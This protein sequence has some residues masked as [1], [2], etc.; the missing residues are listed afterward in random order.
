[1]ND[2]AYEIAKYIANAGYGT[3]GTDVFAGQI[4][5]DQNGIYVIRAGGSLNN[6]NSIANT[7]VDVYI[8]NTQAST[9]ITTLEGIKAYIHRMYDTNID[10]THIYSILVI[11]DVTDVQRDQEYAKVFKITVQVIHRDTGIIS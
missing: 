7:V 1:M 10:N 5:S 3:L 6:Y 2:V 11:G 8:K 9:C 4:P